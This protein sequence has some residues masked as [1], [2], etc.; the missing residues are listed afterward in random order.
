LRQ[1][2]EWRRREAAEVEIR[3]QRIVLRVIDADAR[4]ATVEEVRQ[5]E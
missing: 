2:Q 1:S 4:E 5:I 3:L